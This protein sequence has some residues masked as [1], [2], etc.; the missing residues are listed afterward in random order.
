VALTVRCL[1][2]ADDLE[3]FGRIV[4]SAYHALPG[5]PGEPDYDEELLDVAARV[6]RA[7]VLGAL[8][9][10]APLGSVTYVDGAASPYAEGLEDGEASFRM[11]AVSPAAQGR[12]V[13]EALVRA[14]LDRARGAGRT[15][16][17]IYSGSWMTGAH[18]LYRRLGFV[19]TPER[20][21]EIP[22]LLTL[23]GF[24]AAL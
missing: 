21:W 17:F 6:R 8:D 23:L 12:G 22:G 19:P 7:T 14:C 24:R 4:L 16:V 20:D 1:T 3:Q 9:G 13:G 11:L 18:R 5:H 15:A 2:L 10:M